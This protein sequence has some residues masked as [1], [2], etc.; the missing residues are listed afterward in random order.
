MHVM[1]MVVYLLTALFLGGFG[2]YLI[3]LKVG[4]RDMVFPFVNMLSFWLYLLAV[5]ILTASI[6]VPGGQKGAGWTLYPLQANQEGTPG[7]DLGIILM[8]VSLSVFIIAFY[9]GGFN[10]V[11]TVMQ[12]RNRGKNE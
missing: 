11:T 7:N 12:A 2:N 10:D 5:I 9:M 6:F 4:A 8:I 3:P 1:I